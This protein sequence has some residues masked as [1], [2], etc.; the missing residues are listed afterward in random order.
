[1]L[2]PTSSL[3]AAVDSSV[4]DGASLRARGTVQWRPFVIAALLSVLVGTALYEGLGG[5][6]SSVLPATRAGASSHAGLSRLPLAAQGT[7]S[8]TLG[9]ENPAYRV[10]FSGGGFQAVNPAQRLSARFGRSGIQIGA[11]SVHL[12][13]SLRAV[14]YGTSLRA[15]GAATPRVKA[16]RVTYARTGLSEW[17]A[18]GP[19]GLEQG[20]TIPRAPSHHPA[21]PLT[22]SMALAANARASLASG[23]QSITLGRAG[24]SSLRYGG[25]IA[26]DST[27]RTLHTSLDLHA[28]RVLVRVDTRGARYPLRIDP[29]IQQAKLTG[30]RETGPGVF[31][32]AVALSA[33]GNTALIGGN[34]DS[35]QV[36][37]AWVFTR[38]GS[39]WTQLGKKLTGRREIGQGEF[40][41]AV[42]LSAD[43][44]TALVGGYA[45]NGLVGAAWVF[46]RTSSG[47]VQQGEKL[48][49]GGESGRGFFGANVALSADGNTALIGGPGD[50]GFVGAAWVFTPSQP[51]WTQQ[52]AKLTGGGES[53]AGD[54]GTG[55]ALSADGN[56]VLIGGAGDN[57]GVG[58]AWVFTRSG[59]T[60]TQQG[61]KLAGTGETGEGQFGQGVALSGDGNTALIGGPGDNTQVGAAW[62]FTRSGSTWTQQGAKL[63]GGGEL[64][65]GFLGRRV[66]LSADGNTALIGG[67]ADNGNVGAAWV[68]T[69]SESIWTQREKLT[70]GGET[71]QGLFGWSVALSE[72]ANTAL[73]GG[74]DDNGSIG[75]AWVFVQ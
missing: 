9:A 7:V 3:Q 33:D 14:G 19:L 63:T 70:G 50:N 49:G 67:G 71:G 42:A 10:G 27:G 73:I 43:G 72:K 16:N 4:A 24:R 54:F 29:L 5:G 65:K 69:R 62:V 21:G 1:M 52:G 44:K 25:L 18:N 68:F 66:A 74:P 55:A 53:G 45:D 31:G 38:S 34:D 64:V 11:G 47:F 59:T 6:R 20:F 58:A 61:E 37:A 17:Y 32:E 39:T 2:R 56:T 75:A 30:S 51:T 26:T 12:G 48:T 36:G 60:W 13:L 40:G 22:L 41:Q 57:G 8:A 35:K 23:G 15:V 28:G 46:K